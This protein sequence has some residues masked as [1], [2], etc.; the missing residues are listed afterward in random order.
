MQKF[1]KEQLSP[2]LKEKHSYWEGE[3]PLSERA[4]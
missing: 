3:S 1:L 2:L 4:P